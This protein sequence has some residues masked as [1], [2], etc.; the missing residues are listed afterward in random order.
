MLWR[1][2]ERPVPPE[3]ARTGEQ[4]GSANSPVVLRTVAGQLPS[5][6]TELGFRSRGSSS[7][8]A[9]F[10]RGDLPLTTL[11]FFWFGLV[12]FV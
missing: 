10:S 11:D 2:E 8:T 1:K 3:S 5:L 7:R 4:D 6:P 12:W 9:L